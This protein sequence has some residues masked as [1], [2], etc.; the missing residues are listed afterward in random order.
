MP[1]EKN[2]Y[3]NNI[4]RLE[5]A[6]EKNFYEQE[7]VSKLKSTTKPTN[8]AKAVEKVTKPI[9]INKVWTTNAG[10]CCLSLKKETLSIV[11]TNASVNE[12]FLVTAYPIVP[13]INGMTNNAVIL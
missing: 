9:I 3:P 2:K 12:T 4:D 5:I 6:L 8:S 7:V 11:S 1:E 10:P 13:N